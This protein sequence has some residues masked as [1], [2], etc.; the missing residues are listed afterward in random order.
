VSREEVLAVYEQYLKCFIRNDIA[1]IDAIV[2]Y[3]LT[4]IGPSEARQCA[5]F[6]IDPGELIRMTGWH[7][8]LNMRYEVVAV[9]ADKAHVV[10]H[11]GD[12]VREDGSLIETVSGFYAF[13]RA[14]EGWK[15]YA[16]SDVVVP[17]T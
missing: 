4:Y 10:L 16:L 11:R 9:S 7:T 13:K 6:P 17:A 3:P 1:G 12:R 5:E 2:Q 8:T 14:G 15:M